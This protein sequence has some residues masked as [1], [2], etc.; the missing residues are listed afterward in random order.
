MDRVPSES[1]RCVGRISL[2]QRRSGASSERHRPAQ[3]RPRSRRATRSPV[4]ATRL[5]GEHRQADRRRVEL[6][7]QAT[8]LGSYMLYGTASDFLAALAAT[9]STAPPRRAR[10][11]TGRSSR[12]AA[13]SFTLSPKSAPDHVL[14]A[15]GGGLALVAAAAPARRRSFTPSPATRLRGLPRGGARRQRHAGQG[16]RPPTA[17]CGA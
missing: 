10:P 6:R 5:P 8:G 16:A 1:P 14:A 15:G 17:R 9:R 2:S 11:P 4:G 7:F 13:G 3:P 12:A